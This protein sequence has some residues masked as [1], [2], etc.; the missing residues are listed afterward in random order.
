MITG[1]IPQ[2]PVVRVRVR[3]WLAAARQVVIRGLVT[4]LVMAGVAVVVTG[5]VTVLAG[6][7]G[8]AGVAVVTGVLIRV[9]I[10]LLAVTGLARVVRV[11][12]AASAPG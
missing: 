8:L 6:V 4:G 1:V 11:R 7:T 2:R 3:L 5:R 9:G 12:V 10:V